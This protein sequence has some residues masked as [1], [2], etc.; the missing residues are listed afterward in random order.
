MPAYKPIDPDTK[1]TRAEW[2]IE[3]LSLWE[4]CLDIVERNP[5][6][7]IEEYGTGQ[8]LEAAI[9]VL[10]KSFPMSELMPEDVYASLKSVVDDIDE[11]R[12]QYAR[13]LYL[14]NCDPNLT[15]IDKQSRIEQLDMWKEQ[16]LNELGEE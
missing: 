13:V 4:E 2:M 10:K 14:I 5:N 16:K 15:G 3:V 1:L 9:Y 12:T 7:S 11:I 6:G 8:E